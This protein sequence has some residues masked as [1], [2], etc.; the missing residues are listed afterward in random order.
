M[1]KD[2][3]T[4]ILTYAIKKSGFSSRDINITSPANSAFGD[5]TTTIAMQLGKKEKQDPFL[6][7]EKI[8]QNIEI[9]DPIGSVKIIR[10][11]FINIVLSK[12]CLETT[13]QSILKN[14]NEYGSSNQFDGKKVIV[15]Y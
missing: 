12:N 1:I 5:Y 7:A 6:I 11:G 2:Q 10:P 13:L 9:A 15:E 8:A 14:N 3:I 4:Q